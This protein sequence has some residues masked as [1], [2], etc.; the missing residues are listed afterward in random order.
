MKQENQAIYKMRFRWSL[1]S[2]FKDKEFAQEIVDHNDQDLR[3]E[4]GNGVDKCQIMVDKLP[5]QLW[6]SLY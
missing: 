2:Y 5:N 6:V 4:S 1:I 3:E